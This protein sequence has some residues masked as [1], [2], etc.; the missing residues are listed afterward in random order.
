MMMIAP[1]EILISFGLSKAWALEF[2]FKDF[3]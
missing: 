3:K 1:Q 2:F